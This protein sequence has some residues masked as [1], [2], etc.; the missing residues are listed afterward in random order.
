[1]P[2]AKGERSSL[3]ATKR[4]L[5]SNRRSRAKNRAAFDPQTLEIIEFAASFPECGTGA[6]RLG[7]TAV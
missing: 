6:I 5:R 1:M 2:T 3:G 4:Q 7:E